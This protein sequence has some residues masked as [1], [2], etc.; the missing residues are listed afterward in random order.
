MVERWVSA[1]PAKWEGFATKVSGEW[2]GGGVEF[3]LFGEPRELPEPFRQGE[4]KVYD[5]QIQCPTVAHP[6]NGRLWYKVIKLNPRVGGEADAASK[7][8]SA[9]PFH[10]QALKAHG[11]A[12]EERDASKDPAA[13]ERDASKGASALAFHSSGSYTALW[14]G[15]FFT[16][17]KMVSEDEE[18]EVEQCFV[19]GKTR[20]RVFQKLGR[21]RHVFLFRE[22]LGGGST[23]AFATESKSRSNIIFGQWNSDIYTLQNPQPEQVK[24]KP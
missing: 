13:V 9:L 11:A 18:V 16:N 15:K 14:P 7:D 8:N 17:K 6:E 12:V 2:E 3:N 1:E 19:H 5:W 20:V 23:A 21:R 22:S 24:P 4:E 10:I